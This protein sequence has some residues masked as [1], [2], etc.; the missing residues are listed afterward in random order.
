MQNSKFKK[1]HTIKIL[2]AYEYGLYLLSFCNRSEAAL[3]KRLEQKRYHA[4]EIS[5]AINKLKQYN[6]I[7]DAQTACQMIQYHLKTGKGAYA[8]KSKLLQK[9]FGIDIIN[10]QIKKAEKE[11]PS[12]TERAIHAARRRLAGWKNIPD[13]KKINRLISLLQRHGFSNNAIN[14]VIKRLKLNGIEQLCD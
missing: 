6:F 10:N 5:K 8:I 12:E 14:G 4:D 2:S 9:G 1:R 13:H 7:N 3:K 11:F